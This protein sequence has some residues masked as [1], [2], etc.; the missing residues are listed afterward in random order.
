LF[1]LLQT[2]SVSQTLPRRGTEGQVHYLTVSAEIG[3]SFVLNLTNKM[4]D[5]HSFNK[6]SPGIGNPNKETIVKEKFT[7]SHQ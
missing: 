4:A 7:T 6:D 5:Q 3:H 1:S 2:H